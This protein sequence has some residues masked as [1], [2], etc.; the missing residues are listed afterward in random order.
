MNQVNFNIR[1][2]H[3]IV[4]VKNGAVQ[5]VFSLHCF[6]LFG[7]NITERNHPASFGKGQKPFHMGMGNISRPHN[8]YINHCYILL[9]KS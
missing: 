9:S 4:I 7:I 1:R 8:C 5:P 6:R 3:R 2:Q